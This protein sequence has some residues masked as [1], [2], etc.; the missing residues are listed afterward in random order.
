MSAEKL[1][2]T[3]DHEWVRIED[4]TAIIG[5]TRHAA[6]ELGE[7]VFCELPEVGTLI[8]QADECGSVESVKTVSS[9]F[10][11]LSGEV[12]A[13]NSEIED[14]AAIINE[15]PQDDGWLFK[16]DVAD[17]REVDDLMSEDEYET[18]LDATD[19]SNEEEEED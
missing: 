6:E 13:I 9:I 14:N 3:E 16:L 2:F 1:Y 4:N 7:V 17:M 5:I 11:P 12:I 8:T 15:S 10:T 19:E 18:Y